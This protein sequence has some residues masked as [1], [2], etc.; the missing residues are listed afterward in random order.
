MSDCTENSKPSAQFELPW[1]IRAAAVMGVAVPIG[2]LAHLSH[3]DQRQL[4][5]T[6][7]VLEEKNMVVAA[8]RD[9]FATIA[10]E[11]GVVRADLAT[12]NTLLATSNEA[13]ATSNGLLASER[14]RRVAL[15]S[16]LGQLNEKV[17]VLGEREEAL[18]GIIDLLEGEVSSA[19]GR[20]AKLAASQPQPLDLTHLTAASIA[21]SSDPQLR[22]EN[23]RLRN[24]LGKHDDQVVE[25]LGE[26]S[27]LNQELEMMRDE[28]SRIGAEVGK[29]SK[30]AESQREALGES[31]DGAAL[32]GVSDD[33]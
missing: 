27:V 13:L 9:T 23:D 3:E 11:V 21:A 24:E 25:L 1:V 15:E 19:E 18:R 14:G 17:A 16:D 26:I 8:E 12:S 2:M 33:E 31:F 30:A 32:A 22:L 4:G 7:V 29:L 10:S 6:I 28:R 20:I 5:E